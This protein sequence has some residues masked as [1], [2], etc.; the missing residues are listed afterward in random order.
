MEKDGK[1][2]VYYYH[3]H[4]YKVK[5]AWPQPAGWDDNSWT[6]GEEAEEAYQRAEFICVSVYETKMTGFGSGRKKKES[7]YWS[8]HPKGYNTSDEWFDINRIGHEED[9]YAYLAKKLEEHTGK[10][11]LTILVS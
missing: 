3:N 6:F 7:C 9:K 5:E 11:G 4:P 10:K 8:V 2:R 1:T